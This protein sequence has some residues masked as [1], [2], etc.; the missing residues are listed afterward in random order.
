MEKQNP[1][2]AARNLSIRNFTY[3]HK[4]LILSN[5]WNINADLV[6]TEIDKVENIKNKRR[7]SVIVTG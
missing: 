1:E 5:L 6:L 4:L 7:K 2:Q 3:T